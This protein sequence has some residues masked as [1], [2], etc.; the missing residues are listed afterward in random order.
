MDDTAT[1]DSTTESVSSQLSRLNPAQQQAVIHPGG[2]ALIMAGA[3]SGKTTVLTHH[4][5]WLIEQ[6]ADP[7]TIILV[8]FTN[9]AAGEMSARI[10]RLT[11]APL[12]YAATF[13][14]LCARL[15]RIY[16]AAIGLDNNYVIYDSEDQLS[17]VKQLYKD[18]SWSFNTKPQLARSLISSAKNELLT[19]AEYRQ[20]AKSSAEENSATVYQAYQN[21]LNRANALDFD[22]L[23]VRMVDLLQNS[24]LVRDKLQHQFVHV[25]VDEYQDTNTVQYALTKMLAAPH[26]NIYVVGDFCQSIYSWRGAKY[27]NMLNL[28]ADFPTIRQY[29]LEQNYRSTQ[30]ILTAAS[31]IISHNTTHPTLELWTQ[32]ADGHK[33]E[34]HEFRTADDEAHWVVTTIQQKINLGTLPEEIALLYRTNAQSRPLEDSLIMRQL[35][36]Q[37]IGGT[38]FYERKEI[39]D[40]IAYLR[41]IINSADTVSYARIEKLGKRKLATF[42][43]WTD[44]SQPAIV[45]ELPATLL[46]SVLKQTH[47]QDQFDEQIEEEAER[48]ENITELLRMAGEYQTT[49]QFLENLALLQEH[50][51]ASRQSATNQ[52]VKLMSL[53]SAKGL[54][55]QVVYIIGLEE[56]L[57][58][59]SRSLYN[60]E[61][62]E[63]ERR[64]LYVGITRAKTQVYLSHVHFRATYGQ[65]SVSIPSRFLSEIDAKV[66]SSASAP[67]RRPATNDD[68]IIEESPFEPYRPN[69]ASVSHQST[70]RRRRT[71]SSSADSHH[72]SPT[73]RLVSDDEL[74]VITRAEHSLN[75]Y[76]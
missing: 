45:S 70:F 67:L 35:P 9:K 17:L 44:Q 22:D 66:L 47:Y 1:H 73:R 39:K 57:L 7:N 14:S 8:T 76:R 68:F 4:A 25:L 51:A 52:S 33:L 23:L 61:E 24:A 30:H 21:A 28:L 13:H 62:L 6:G 58:P 31:Q 37:L 29:K 56:G 50:D 12:T 5:A 60:T 36:Y 32:A 53:H 75:K 54:E 19:P 40:L 16:G 69:Q 18:N 74:D 15:L 41:L 27:T 26:H 48:L 59:H 42:I 38:R 10:A 2:P 49:Y 34:L 43:T 11:G 20:Q 72:S 71:N 64:L 46:K 65:P 3:G 63:E 55:F